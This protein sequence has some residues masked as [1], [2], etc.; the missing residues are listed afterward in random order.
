MADITLYKTLKN[1]SVF[2]QAITFTIA[3]QF[4]NSSLE[5][6]LHYRRFFIFV[7]GALSVIM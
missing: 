3:K 7:I 2:N 5:E 6:Y 4:T 1:Y